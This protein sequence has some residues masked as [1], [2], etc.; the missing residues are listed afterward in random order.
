MP[1][2]TRGLTAIGDPVAKAQATAG[3]VCP[4]PPGSAGCSCGDPR[5]H[6]NAEKA[7]QITADHRAFTGE[8]AGPYSSGAVEGNVNRII[9]W[10][11]A[12]QGCCGYFRAMTASTTGVGSPLSANRSS[13]KPASRTAC[14][15]S[16]SG[17]WVAPT[18]ART[19]WSVQDALVQW[20]LR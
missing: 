20:P 14:I 15:S 13:L 18:L 19:P 17:R 10:N 6:G 11:Q 3:I 16:G 5:Q 8:R 1:S 2:A 9:L 12:C 4:F 7:H